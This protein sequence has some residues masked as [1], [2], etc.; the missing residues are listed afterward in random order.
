[1]QEIRCPFCEKRPVSTQCK[2]CYT[3]ICHRCGKT[4]ICPD[5]LAE[6]MESEHFNEARPYARKRVVVESDL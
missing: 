4:Q 1:M 5:C 3:E 2:E 6:I